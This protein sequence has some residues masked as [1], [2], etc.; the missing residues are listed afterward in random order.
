MPAEAKLLAVLAIMGLAA[1]TVVAKVHVVPLLDRLPKRR[2]LVV[3]LTPQ[4]F[5]TVGALALFPGVGATPAEW[6]R[7]LAIGD[8]VTAALAMVAVLTLHASWRH[9][10]KAAWV[11][12]AF[13]LV[14]LLH[15]AFNSV[16]LQVAPTLGPIAY[17]V[18]FGVPLML[19]C[20]LL[21][22]RAL[23]RKASD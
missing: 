3:V 14:D 21:A 8:G 15:N 5:R 6:A 20:H 7:P 23:M 9:A 11:A 22:I 12:T 10:M 1:W 13:G 18:A 19:V 2:A 17:V 16:R 4:M